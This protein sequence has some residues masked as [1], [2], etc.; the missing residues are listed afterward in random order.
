MMKKS[1]FFLPLLSRTV[2]VG[3]EG[4]G[5]MCPYIRFLKHPQVSRIPY[6]VL[7]FHLTCF[8]FLGK[9]S[10]KVKAATAIFFSTLLFTRIKGRWQ[11]DDSLGKHIYQCQVS[12]PVS[13]LCWRKTLNFGLINLSSRHEVVYGEIISISF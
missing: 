10:Q 13:C 2:W 12:H 3:G 9:P 7:L 5:A 11:G 4:G 8:E 6:F 1:V